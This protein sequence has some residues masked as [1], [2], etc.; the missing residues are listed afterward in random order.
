M[1]YLPIREEEVP[2]LAAALVATI[3]M[4]EGA[5]MTLGGLGDKRTASAFRKQIKHM[6]KLLELVEDLT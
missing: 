1:L 5:A 2:V 3:E 6:Q 4:W